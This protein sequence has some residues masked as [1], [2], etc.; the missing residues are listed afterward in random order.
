MAKIWLD[1][2]TFLEKTIDIEDM[3]EL[4][5]RK[6][7]KRNEKIKNEIEKK[8]KDEDSEIKITNRGGPGKS[9]KVFNINTGEVKILKSAKE[10]SKYIKVSCSHASYLARENKSTE[11]GWKAEYIQEVSDGISKCGASN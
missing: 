8:I 9:I 2:G 10:A 11:D 4:N 1:A 5:L 6:V 3:F 7:R